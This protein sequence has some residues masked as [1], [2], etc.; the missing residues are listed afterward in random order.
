MVDGAPLAWTYELH[1][2]SA[3]QGLRAELGVHPGYAYGTGSP[4]RRHRTR[5]PPRSYWRLGEEEGTAANSA[6]EANLGK[7]RGTYQNATLTSRR[8]HHRHPHTAA[9]FD[10][11]ASD[12]STCPPAR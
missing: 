2:R 9:S 8:R 3:E 1:R 6:N 11:A 10:G 12:V 7:D 4:L 5:L